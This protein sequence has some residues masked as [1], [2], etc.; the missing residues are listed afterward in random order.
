M[1]DF[2]DLGNAIAEATGAPVTRA[3]Y[4]IQTNG[5]SSTPSPAAQQSP[6]DK[7]L[8]A[9]GTTGPVADIARSIY[10]QES[11]AG[12]NTKTSNAN[13]VGGMQVQPATFSGVAD[14]GWD[15][16][17]P[18]QNARAGIR[19]VKQMYGQ[20]GGDPV[21]TAAG[22]YGGPNGIEKARQGIA[23]SDPRNPNAPNTLQYGQQVAARLPQSSPAVYDPNAFN[24][25]DI[26]AALTGSGQA[27]ATQAQQ[28]VAGPSQASQ[29]PGSNAVAPPSD[30]GAPATQQPETWWD[31]LKGLGEAAASTASGMVAGVIGPTAG[32][33]YGLTHGYG[34]PQG[35]KNASDVAANVSDAMTY[36]PKTQA[37]QRY[38]QNVGDAVNNSGIAALA[39]ISE[40]SALGSIA[41]AAIDQIKGT[42]PISNITQDVAHI[43]PTMKPRVKLNID[44]SQTPIQQAPPITASGP[45]SVGAAAS[46]YSQQAAAS[47]ASPEM[48]AAIAKAEENGQLNSTA[49]ARHIEASS[50]PVPVDLTAGQATGDVNILSHEQNTRGAQP[51]L[52]E[53]FNGQNG[54]LIENINA[55]RDQAAPDV[56]GANHVENG[57]S[58]INSY[59]AKDDLANTDISAKY[60]A[61]K[62]ANGG[63]F[64]LKGSDFVNSADAALKADNVTRFLPPEVG[65]ILGDLRD[66]GP[67]TVNDFENYRTIL[68]QQARK[69]ARSG[70]GTAEHAI[71]VVRNSLES[72]PMSDE[73]AAIKPL[74]DAARS[75]AKARFDAL[76]ED[77]AYNAA[78][79][80]TVAP[81]DFIHKFVVNGKVG[82]VG[83]MQANLADDQ[84]AAQAIASGA[85]NHLKNRAGVG[86]DAGNFSQAGYNK[87]LQAMAPKLNA[88]VPPEQAQQLQTLGNVSRYTTEQP[89]G[90]Y[91]N[92]SNTLVGSMANSAKELGLG[93]LNAKTYGASGLIRNKLAERAA[94]K[95]AAKSLEVGAGLTKISGFPK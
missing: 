38:T 85:I 22:Y 54:Q 72:I 82:D 20:A 56:F 90:A 35:V 12:S 43:D 30:H 36:Q 47:G 2:S 73:A 52:A 13:A 62:D 64:P 58:V 21:L 93:V 63:D 16:N 57:Q 55:I 77:P 31:K 33:A 6:L 83:I 46:S 41:P 69:A 66:G 49:A 59:L 3:T 23:V 89:R 80:G 29:I 79:N 68:A 32:L 84:S 18:V 9:E 60:Q 86:N 27:N 71:N 53:R 19:Y 42:I 5:T 7:A 75:A 34:S 37:G 78:V 44:G 15:I 28:T 94:S 92:N 67:M 1:D 17:D 70:D 48:V 40:I 24:A 45:Q 26:V 74:A 61:L 95:S 76:R 10:T 39:P 91:V 51:G 81:D 4:T 88:L 87:A 50:L 11:G 14:K 65:G 25:D 8:A